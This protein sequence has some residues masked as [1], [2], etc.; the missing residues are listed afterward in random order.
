MNYAEEMLARQMMLWRSICALLPVE[1]E[2]E[3]QAASKKRLAFEEELR[4]AQSAQSSG[5]AVGNGRLRGGAPL[6]EA[7][8][9]AVLFALDELRYGT[10]ERELSE[11]GHL[12]GLMRYSGAAARG[13][14]SRAVDAQ[15]TDALARALLAESARRSVRGLSDHTG[16]AAY[17]TREMLHG[18]AAADAGAV[19]AA[20]L[21][22]EAA[23]PYSTP[24][25]PVWEAYAWNVSAQE[26]SR[27]FERDSRRYDAAFIRYE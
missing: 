5:E 4:A 6:D 3:V 12:R 17:D 9:R 19:Y 1:P 22:G 10:G 21:Q 11:L 25:A 24:P 14:A 15:E 26:I 7:V 27:C 13:A 23:R 2:D 18:A 20:P 8:R 16:D